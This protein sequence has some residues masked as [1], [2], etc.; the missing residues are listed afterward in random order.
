MVTLPANA[1]VGRQAMASRAGA[2]GQ[3]EVTR[4]RRR[5]VV[6]D[7]NEDAADLLS[8]LLEQLGNST[9]IAHDA[10]AALVVV[11]EFVPDLAVLDIGLPEIDGYELA[12]RL[13]RLP[14]AKQLR[15]VALTGYG[16]PSDRERAL[17][18]GFDAHLVKPVAV[19]ALE[20]VIRR[21]AG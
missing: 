13:R 14:C 19:D 20:A 2:N 3:P 17:A 6:V 10:R 4:G 1:H 16:Q 21:L 7:D 8:V 9:R 12:R 18:A 11:E 5:I 15:L